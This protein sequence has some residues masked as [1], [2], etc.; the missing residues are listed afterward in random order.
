MAVV[1]HFFLQPFTSVYR[2]PL[3]VCCGVCG[4]QH[5]RQGSDSHKIY[6]LGEAWE[7]AD[8]QVINQTGGLAHPG[9]SETWGLAASTFFWG[10]CTLHP[11]L[12]GNCGAS[13]HSF[14][15]WFKLSLIKG[16][17]SFFNGVGN[18]NP[19]Q[20]SCL[21]IPMDRGTWW[22]AVP[23][24]AKSWTQLSINIQNRLRHREQTWDCQGEEGKRRDRVGV[25]G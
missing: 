19:L 24:V 10:R 3:C 14:T 21:E 20:Y 1:L 13:S 22:A 7:R 17:K 11:H 15:S 5:I 16:K 23:G 8:G 4:H 18:G 25:W 9:A 6:I 12:E 2:D